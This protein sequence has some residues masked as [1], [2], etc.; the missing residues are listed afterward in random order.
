MAY[1]FYAMLNRM[2]LINRWSL[3]RNTSSE[4]ISEHS[5]QVAILAHALAY[6][7]KDHFSEGRICPSPETVMAYAVF[8]DAS[9]II[10]GDMP[11]PIKYFNPELR[12]A[13]QGAE[14]AA[15]ERLL[16]M[17]PDDMR[18]HYLPYFKD[19]ENP[20]EVAI[21]ELVKAADKLSAYIKCVE[22][23]SQ[24]NNEFLKAKDQCEEKILAMDLPELKY[25]TEHYLDAFRLSLD[26]LQ[27]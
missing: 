27:E 19:A 24:G 7:R 3:M 6:I 22:E 20:E 23:I 18:R 21:L 11:T 25:F 16:S 14:D 1:G 10:T 9:E 8:H 15:N 12:E 5:L 4:N 26:E 13:Y 17:L 2:R